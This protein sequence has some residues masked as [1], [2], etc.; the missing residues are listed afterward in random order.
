[1]AYDTGLYAPELSTRTYQT[2]FDDAAA[3]L[4]AGR[5]VILDATFQLRVGRDTARGLAQQH[6]VPLLVVE[7]QCAA[8]EVRRRL[9][10]RVERGDSESDA[11]WNV[12]L[13]QCRR[14]EAFGPGEDRLV[15]DTRAPL[16][17]LAGRIET[18]LRDRS[19]SA[20]AL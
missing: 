16:V 4:A 18:T 17:A 20:P 9:Q 6:G 5:G 1:V 11:D 7:C 14:F 8:E 12:Y 2:M 3:S 10:Q 13:E 15:I 19:T